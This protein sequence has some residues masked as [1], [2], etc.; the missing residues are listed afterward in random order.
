MKLS[1]IIKVIY[2]FQMLD[3]IYELFIYIYNNKINK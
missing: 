1:D 2:V 3:F